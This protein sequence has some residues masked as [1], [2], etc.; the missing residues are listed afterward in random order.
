MRHWKLHLTILLVGWPSFIAGY[1][2]AAIESSF[3]SGAYTY[4]RIEDAGM[5]DYE[6]AANK[7]PS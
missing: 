1:L 2:Y 7:E 5:K 6:S 3:R 4:T